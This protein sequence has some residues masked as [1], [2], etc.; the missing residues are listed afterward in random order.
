MESVF[1]TRHGKYI[2][3]FVYQWALF[4]SE[5]IELLRMRTQ[6]KTRLQG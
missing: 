3:Q 4:L 5:N 1:L 6:E 2:W